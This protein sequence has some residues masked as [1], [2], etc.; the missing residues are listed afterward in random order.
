MNIQAA[1]LKSRC[2]GHWKEILA[3]FGINPEMLKKRHGPCPVCG[4]KDRFRFDDW[5]GD[6]MFVC[7][8]CGAGDGLRLIELYNR[9]DFNRTLQSVA[10]YM[11]ILPGFA[12]RM[13]QKPVQ[14]EPEKPDDKKRRNIQRLWRSSVPA[15]AGDLVDNYLRSRGIVLDVLPEV[16]RLSPSTWCKL[17]DD[18]VQLIP[19]MVA[20]VDNPKGELICVHRTYLS[21]DGNGKAAIEKPKRLMPVAATGDIIGGAIRL[22]PAC[23]TLGLAEGIET[24]LSAHMLTTLPVWATISAGGLASVVLPPQVKHVVIFADNDRN[25]K[26]KLCAM[27]LADRLKQEG[28][29]GQIRIPPMTGED[30]N[31]VLRRNHHG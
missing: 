1:E 4:G 12:P 22:F 18:D 21:A 14:Q 16:L 29:T 30:W 11:G 23:Q 6:G 28:R 9:W 13:P 3:H 19:A 5:Q 25:G 8:Q 31:D 2:R 20:R 27:Q 10:Q 15:K 24:A 7:N 26:S 17:G